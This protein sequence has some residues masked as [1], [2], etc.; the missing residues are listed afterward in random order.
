MYLDIQSEMAKASHSALGKVMDFIG[1]VPKRTEVE[2]IVDAVKQDHEDLKRFI[3]ILKNKEMRSSIKRKVYPEFIALLTSHSHA[4]SVVLPDHNAKTIEGCI[5]QI[6]PHPTILELSKWMTQ[7][8][9]LAEL[10]E[11]HV[12]EEE[13]G[14][15][16]EVQK[17]ICPQV[18]RAQKLVKL[19]KNSH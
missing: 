19:H 14:L 3:K 11:H 13:S 9:V 6:S 8:Q 10:V 4:L 7:V 1:T 12:K 16:P 5:E 15:L 2:S 18:A 17:Q